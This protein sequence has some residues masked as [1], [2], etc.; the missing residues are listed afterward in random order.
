MKSSLLA[1]L[2]LGFAQPLLAAE[3]EKLSAFEPGAWWLDHNG[4]HISAH[5]GG[6]L[7]HQGHCA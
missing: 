6:I 2:A 7:C 4:K 1:I 5:G 3:P